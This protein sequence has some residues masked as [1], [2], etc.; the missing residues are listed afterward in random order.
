MTVLLKINPDVARFNP[1]AEFDS[2]QDLVTS[3]GLTRGQ[4][5]AALER[6]YQAVE[7][8]LAATNEGMPPSGT[9]SYDAQ[10]LEDIDNSRIQLSRPATTKPTEEKAAAL[11]D[12]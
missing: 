11:V 2:P 7:R 12:F 6:W 3:N 5:L 8:R 1:E 10:L 4:K 9:T